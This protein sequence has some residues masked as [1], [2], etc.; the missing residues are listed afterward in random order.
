MEIGWKLGGRE[1]PE[2]IFGAPISGFLRVFSRFFAYNSPSAYS[3][4]GASLKGIICMLFA[5]SFVNLCVQNGPLKGPRSSA[6]QPVTYKE[7]YKLIKALLVY[8]LA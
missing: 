7:A 3:I 8:E 1:P 5:T 2:G 6:P 4:K